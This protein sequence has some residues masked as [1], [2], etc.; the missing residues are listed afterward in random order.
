MKSPNIVL[1][2]PRVRLG[3][4]Y[5]ALYR[6]ARAGP[7]PPGRRPA[8]VVRRGEPA[9]IYLVPRVSF[10]SVSAL[11]SLA[12]K[13][14]IRRQRVAAVR[15][16]LERHA[17]A[18]MSGR[19]ARL[20]GRILCYHSVGQP[21]WG[22]NDVPPALFRQQ[23]AIAIE[24]G[25][26]FVAPAELGRTGGTPRD[27][28]ITFDD[29]M[30]SVM[31]R[32]APILAEF[33]IP[34][35]VF[36]VSAWVEG[37]GSFAQGTFLDWQELAQLTG[38]AEIGSHSAT[39]PDFGRLESDRLEHELGESRRVIQRKLGVSCNSFAIPFGQSVNWTPAAQLAAGRA[40][41]DLVYAQAEETRSPGTV[42]RTFVT[43][44]DRPRIFRALLRGAYDR[45][46]EWM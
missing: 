14:G 30:T 33:G 29:G 25:F 22:V 46:E 2:Y 11:K 38:I 19:R 13:L 3:S 7:V 36:V 21:G 40:G 12:R 18:T 24:E 43:G 26:R 37:R 10:A 5:L 15:M 32:A 35:S 27:L 1:D 9:C 28:A 16:L 45:W 34:W 31:T 4:Q 39:H 23:I 44:H 42:P 41:Y 17:L 6:E 8:G 20:R